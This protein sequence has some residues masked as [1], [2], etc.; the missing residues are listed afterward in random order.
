MGCPLCNRLSEYQKLKSNLFA[1]VSYICTIDQ[2]KNN[3]LSRKYPYNK[4]VLCNSIPKMTQRG[5]KAYILHE[6]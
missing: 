3:F 1:R 2:Q 5:S 4:I 6:I